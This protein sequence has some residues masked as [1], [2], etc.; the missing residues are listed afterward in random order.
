[1]TNYAEK[2]PNLKELLHFIHQDWDIMFEWEGRE[3]NYQ[4]AIRKLKMDDSPEVRQKN[5][6]ELRELVSS[7][8]DEVTLRKIVNKDFRSAFYPPGIGLTYHEWLKVIL[9]I[10]EEPIEKTRSEFLPKFVGEYAKETTP[11]I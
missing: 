9:S 6:N 7:N 5:I 8:L 11:K 2:F 4:A 1:M 10:L 3:P